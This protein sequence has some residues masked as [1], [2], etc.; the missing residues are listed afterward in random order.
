MRQLGL[1][2]LIQHKE[3]HWIIITAYGLQL[4]NMI[5]STSFRQSNSKSLSRLQVGRFENYRHLFSIIMTA[6]DKQILNSIRQSY[7]L[8]MAQ[9]HGW[10]TVIIWR[11]WRKSSVRR[12][13]SVKVQDRETTNIVFK[14]AKTISIEEMV[15]KS[16]FWWSGNAVPMPSDSLPKQIMYS[17]LHNGKR[18][19]AGQRKRYK[20]SLF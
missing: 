2:A 5:H 6:T 8:R 20:D 3:Q 11:H 4:E 18:S 16:Q 17:E 10:F 12:I 13:L 19:T 15:I 7:Y 1:L 14:Q 9:K